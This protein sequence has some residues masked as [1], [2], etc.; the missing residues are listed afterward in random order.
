MKA[1]FVYVYGY[2]KKMTLSDT[3]RYWVFKRDR[4]AKKIDLAHISYGR[5]SEYNA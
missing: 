1:Q 2:V 5:Q 3:C 4:L